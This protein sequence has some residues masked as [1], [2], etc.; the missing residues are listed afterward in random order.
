M[1]PFSILISAFAVLMLGAVSAHADTRDV[2][3]ISDIPVDRTAATTR[4]AEAQA[5]AEAK[6]IGLRRLIARLTLPEDR[7]ALGEEFYSFSNANELAAAVDVEDERRSTTVYR[8]NLSVVYNPIRVRAILNQYGVPYIDQ[9][10]ALSLMAPVAS[11]ATLQTEWKAAW[12][13]AVQGALSPFITGLSHY[14]ADANWATLSSEARAVGASNAILAEL[15]TSD[16]TYAVR[17][18]RVTAA[19]NF[20]IGQTGFV[21]TMEEAVA[22]ASAYLDAA[23]KTRSIVRGDE[24]RTESTATVRYRDQ[25]SWN[26]VR[27]ALAGSPLISGFKVDA[28]AS[29]GALVSFTYAG[30]PERLQ[31]EFGQQGIVLTTGDAGWSIALGGSRQF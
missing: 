22:A 13:E 16:T 21:A 9:Q 2:Y 29:D 30:S 24:V 6:I 3:T 4:E 20:S 31:T 17:L 8:A 1:K 10:A 26:R 27:S 12:P 18:T 23:W 11:N 28:I 14:R 25:R 5:F 15:V 7:A 19:G